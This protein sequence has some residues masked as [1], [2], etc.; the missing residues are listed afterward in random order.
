MTHITDVTLLGA[1]FRAG[2]INVAQYDAGSARS[3]SNETLQH[4]LDRPTIV[5]VQQLHAELA[6][7]GWGIRRTNTEQTT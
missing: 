7:L 6:A 3:H 1:L 2:F 5:R 4:E